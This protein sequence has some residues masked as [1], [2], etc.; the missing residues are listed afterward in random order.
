MKNT[1]KSV[2]DKGGLSG[3]KL[4]TKLV[5]LQ[6]QNREAEAQQRD[7]EYLDQH[8][9]PFLYVALQKLLENKPE[10]P[11]EALA[12]ILQQLQ[13]SA[14]TIHSRNLTNNKD[15]APLRECVS[16]PTET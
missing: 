4:S 1:K 10:R 8:I 6:R 11:L 5:K 15:H 3:K 16:M 14:P 12:D 13:D 7:Q 9:L 2:M